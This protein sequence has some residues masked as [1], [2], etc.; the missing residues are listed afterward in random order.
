MTTAITGATGQLGRLITQKLKDKLPADQ[1]VALVRSPEKAANLGVTARTFD[2]DR[3]ETLAPALAGVDTLLLISGS[4]VGKRGPQHAAVIAAAKQAGVGRIVYTSLLRADTTPLSLGIEHS[5][6]ERAILAS[7]IPHTILRNGWYVE[8][9]ASGVAAALAHGALIGAAGDGRIA[10]AA[11]ADYA[12]AAVAVL[13]GPGHDGKTYEL[14]GDTAFT[15]TDLAAELSRQ[16]GR[17][18]PY[19]N[20]SATNYAA[21]LAG[22]GLPAPV[23]DMLAG[24]DVDTSNGALFDDN[25]QLS[26]LIGHPTTS[27]A[28]GVKALIG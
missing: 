16:T 25:G 26:K 28:D 5:E 4:E 18:I 23:A 11:R 9:Y 15:L 10:A 12:D 14:A 6:T 27:L 20:L 13:T 24:W 7:G 19:N 22:T 3:P 21:A 8:N 2:Y 1:I 17:D